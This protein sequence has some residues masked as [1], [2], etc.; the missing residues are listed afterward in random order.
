[1]LPCH[2]SPPWHTWCTGPCIPYLTEWCPLSTRA[3]QAARL[4]TVGLTKLDEPRPMARASELLAL[5]D[6][7]L[8]SVGQ[9]AAINGRRSRR[10][11]DS[12]A[13]RC[14]VSACAHAACDSTHSR[15]AKARPGAPCRLRSVAGWRGHSQLRVILAL[16]LTL[17]FTRTLTLT[18]IRYLIPGPLI[19]TL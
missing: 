2:V 16:T 11:V 7:A 15:V 14:S 4:A 5:I 10:E 19:L 12:P 8:R 9:I 1:M 13:L 3:A 17:C 6:V 18:F